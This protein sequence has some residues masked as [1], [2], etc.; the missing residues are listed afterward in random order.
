MNMHILL[1]HNRSFEITNN[2]ETLQFNESE[3]LSFTFVEHLSQFRLPNGAFSFSFPY[4]MIEVFFEYIADGTVII[5]T[6]MYDGSEKQELILTA[7][8]FFTTFCQALYDYFKRI[9]ENTPLEKYVLDNNSKRN[10][11]RK[12]RWEMYHSLRKNFIAT[13]NKQ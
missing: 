4:D 1:R 5:G 13:I 3:E 11:T 8:E 10:K 2:S 12:W 9:E 6:A 7:S